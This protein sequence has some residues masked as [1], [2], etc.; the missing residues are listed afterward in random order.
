MR[1]MI[2]RHRLKVWKGKYSVWS[3]LKLFNPNWTIKIK[4]TLQLIYFSTGAVIGLKNLI[5]ATTV[6]GLALILSHCRSFCR[7]QI[8]LCL[9]MRVSFVY[10]VPPRCFPCKR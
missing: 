8:S 1:T 10:S 6:V 2:F 5:H 3:M 7:Q 4:C 9:R